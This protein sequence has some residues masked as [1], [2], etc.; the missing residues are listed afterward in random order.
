MDKNKIR[1]LFL[2]SLPAV[3]LLLFGFWKGARQEAENSF[4]TLQSDESFGL[5]AGDGNTETE[6]LVETGSHTVFVHIG[7]CV[8]RPGVYEVEA[9]SRVIDAV[10]KAGGVT[11]D[12]CVDAINMAVP[13][14]DGMKIIIPSIVEEQSQ[15]GTIN[16]NTATKKE[17]MNIPGVGEVRAKAIISYREKHGGFEKVEDIMQVEGIKK[18][19]FEKIKDSISVY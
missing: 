4:S 2:V 10:T 14:E 17:L 16:I 13:V 6:S 15:D 3:V 12:A 5:Q 1:Y 19:T 8:C 7:G 9:G 11:E 18:A